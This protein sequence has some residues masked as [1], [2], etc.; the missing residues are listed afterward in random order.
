MQWLTKWYTNNCFFCMTMSAQS[1]DHCTRQK[2]REK[3]V[4]K[5]KG[6]RNTYH[7]LPAEHTQTAPLHLGGKMC[8]PAV[9]S[10]CQNTPCSTHASSC[11]HKQSSFQTGNLW[12]ISMFSS[13]YYFSMCVCV[14]VC[15]TMC[16]CPGQP[17]YKNRLVLSSCLHIH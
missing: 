9:P 7:W 12:A 5:G 1:T 16:P 6:T 2:S 8:G 17:D 15:A 10:L 14:T 4:S 3:R 11:L 13:I